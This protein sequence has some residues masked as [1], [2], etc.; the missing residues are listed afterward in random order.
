MD[1]LPSGEG[2]LQA[3]GSSKM[4]FQSPEPKKMLPCFY[5]FHIDVFS[6][7]TTILMH[8]DQLVSFNMMFSRRI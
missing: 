3:V 8:F 2:P 4:I 5:C 1:L 7:F 6:L